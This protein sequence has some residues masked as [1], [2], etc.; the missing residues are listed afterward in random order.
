ME[1]SILILSGGLDSTV[2]A[3]LSKES[4]SPVLALTFDYGQRSVQHEVQ[5]AANTARSLG[6][7]HRVMDLP[8]LGQMTRTALVNRTSSLSRPSLAELEDETASRKSA[9]NVWVPNRNGLFLNIAACFADALGATRLVTGFNREEAA[10]FPDNSI[11]FAEAANHFFYYATQAHPVVESPTLGLNKIEIVQ[12]AVSLG[13][14]FRDLWFCYEAGPE[15]CHRC[16]SCM[17][18][19]RAFD[20]AGIP[21]PWVEETLP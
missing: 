17:R 8:W 20:A 6:T 19:F 5:A 14:R 7:E 1:K 21:D 15:P 4:S 3:H 13:I 12:K 11:P 16:E 9:A 18:N 2:A 10:T